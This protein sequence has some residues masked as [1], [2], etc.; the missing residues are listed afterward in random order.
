MSFERK[1]EYHAIVERYLGYVI[2]KLMSYFSY[3]LVVPEYGALRQSKTWE[4]KKKIF[5][6]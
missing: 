2:R 1:M 4:I 3:K 6:T 5:L